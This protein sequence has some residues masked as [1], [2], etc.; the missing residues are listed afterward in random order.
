MKKYTVLLSL[1]IFLI[2]CGKPDVR[3]YGGIVVDTTGAPVAQ[4]TVS[5]IYRQGASNF[6][7]GTDGVRTLDV[8]ETDGTFSS[9]FTLRK[10]EYIDYFSIHSPPPNSKSVITRAYNGASATD[11][12]IVIP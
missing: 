1:S 9:K 11:M 3:N 7:D 6:S 12:R 10:K 2:S 5:V 8:T 4:A